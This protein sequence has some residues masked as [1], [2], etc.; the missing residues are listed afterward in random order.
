MQST[1]TNKKLSKAIVNIIICFDAV[2]K[3]YNSTSEE[4]KT[5]EVHPGHFVTPNAMRENVY[6]NESTPSPVNTIFIA[7]NSMINGVEEKRLSKK[8]SNL[9]VRYLN[10]ALVEDMFYNL[11]PFMR[12]KPHALILHV[13]TNNVVSDSSKVIPKKIKSLIS[14]IKTN[15]PER[16]III[17]QPIQR[18]D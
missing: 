7:G 9:K 11:V 5:A 14:C 15:N 16:R 1:T 10:A 2:K 3:I 18:T 4:T 17:Y 6:H 12:K 13:G 8:N